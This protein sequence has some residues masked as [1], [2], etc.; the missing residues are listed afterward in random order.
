MEN[1]K[2]SLLKVLYQYLKPYK[3]AFIGAFIMGTLSSLT[4]AVSAYVEGMITSQLMA[5][6]LKAKG[7]LPTISMDKVTL[8]IMILVGIYISK[9]F[10]QLC[11][12]KWLTNSVQNAMRDLRNAI[13]N[14]LRK[15][16][17]SYYDA[18]PY[19]D[20]LSKV[21]NDVEA[22]SNALQQSFAK[23]VGGILSIILAI[24]FM[25]FINVQLALIALVVIPMSLIITKAVVHFSQKSFEQQQKTLGELN[26]NITEVYSGFNEIVLYNQ[27]EEAYERFS[28]VNEALCKSGFKAQFISS[29]M[30]PLLTFVT[31]VIL[32]I[33]SV[34]GI[35]MVIK[36][37]LLVGQLQSFTRYIWQIN[38][39][40]SQISQLSSQIQS[41]I[42]AF[43]RIVDLL[44]AKEEIAE[45]VELVDTSVMKGSVEFK[46]VVF[47]YNE[48]N[49]LMK[50]LSFKV[51]SGQM[52]AIVGHTGAGKTTIMNLLLRFYDITGGEILI[53][54]INILHMK[55]EQ[56]RY[57][58]AMVLQDTWLF[59]GTII[60][61][62]RYGNLDARDD[63]VVDAAKMAKVHHYIRTLSD[64]YN[65]IIEEGE[66]NISSGEKQLLTIA[67]AILKDP[68]ILILDEATSS[69]DTRLEK[70]LQEAMHAV[71][72]TRTS[73]VI[74]H[75]LSTIRNADLI[76][77]LKDGDI[78]E[79]GN[80][81]SLLKDEG[82]YY[83]LYQSQFENS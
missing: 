81:D 52:V 48:D 74:A 54:G 42:A 29:I 59:N 38:D 51:E 72:K 23:I 58:F 24:G 26:G 67:R 71:M 37:T 11:S 41:A 30:T 66:G 12:I 22:V 64:G 63:E 19:G 28:Q 8:L 20:I 9:V 7:E 68:T 80:H 65:T 32:G 49:I 4:I 17:V 27:Q 56:L 61:N 40:I 14:K 31:Y 69:V 39:P 21:T 73:F 78:I 76:L 55:R 79:Q 43:S 1:K 46:N 47:G 75:R 25:F 60:E 3:W 57:L 36:G 15:M 50:D 62:L 44:N 5:D 83:Q 53:D 35:G 10:V 18:Q 82:Y 70:M 77:V 45:N 16:P 13:L 6:V 33:T 2:A 34:L